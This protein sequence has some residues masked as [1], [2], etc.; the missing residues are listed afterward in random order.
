MSSFSRSAR[1]AQV[2]NERDFNKLPNRFHSLF[3]KRYHANFLRIFIQLQQRVSVQKIEEA[4]EDGQRQGIVPTAKSVQVTAFDTVP[5]RGRGD[6]PHHDADKYLGRRRGSLDRQASDADVAPSVMRRQSWSDNVANGGLEKSVEGSLAPSKRFCVDLHTSAKEDVN[7]YLNALRA[8]PPSGWNSLYGATQSSNHKPGEG[9]RIPTLRH[10]ASP[11]TGSC[12]G[13]SKLGSLRVLFERILSTDFSI[14]YQHG[15]QTKEGNRG[16]SVRLSSAQSGTTR[17]AYD[18]DESGARSDDVS[19]TTADSGT[20]DASQAGSCPSASD[21]AVFLYDIVGHSS[22]DDTTPFLRATPRGQRLPAVFYSALVQERLRQSPLPSLPSHFCLKLSVPAKFVGDASA[23]DKVVAD[24]EQRFMSLWGPGG[25]HVSQ[26]QWKTGADKGGMETR[27]GANKRERGIDEFTGRKPVN[28]TVERDVPDWQGGM[29]DHVENV[30]LRGSREREDHPLVWL[31]DSPDGMEYE[32][33]DGAHG[34]NLFS[35]GDNKPGM[36]TAE[37]RESSGVERLVLAADCWFYSPFSSLVM[38]KLSTTDVLT[39]LRLALLLRPRKPSASTLG[40]GLAPSDSLPSASPPFGH[41]RCA[42]PSSHHRLWFRIL[43]DIFPGDPLCDSFDWSDIHNWIDIPRHPTLDS[44]YSHLQVTKHAGS[45]LY[46]ETDSGR[47]EDGCSEIAG[48]IPIRGDSRSMN[49][50]TEGTVRGRMTGSTTAKRRMVNFTA[51]HDKHRSRRSSRHRRRCRFPEGLRHISTS[52]ERP[53]MGT[54]RETITSA[55]ESVSSTGAAF[56]VTSD[57]IGPLGTATSST[58]T[59]NHSSLPNPVVDS[60]TVPQT[61]YSVA[62]LSEKPSVISGI[63]SSW[64]VPAETSSPNGKHSPSIFDV[65]EDVPSGHSVIDYSNGVPDVSFL[66]LEGLLNA[67]SKKALPFLRSAYPKNSETPWPSQGIWAFNNPDDSPQV[68]AHMENLLSSIQ[69]VKQYASIA[70]RTCSNENLPTS[71]L[72]RDSL[73]SVTETNQPEDGRFMTSFSARKAAVLSSQ[74]DCILSRPSG[75]YP[76]GAVFTPTELSVCRL[77]NADSSA[78]SSLSAS[79]TATEVGNE[80]PETPR[81]SWRSKSPDNDPTMTTCSVPELRISSPVC[82]ICPLP[83]SDSSI[84]NFQR[85]AD[86]DCSNRDDVSDGG[87]SNV[88]TCMS[89]RVEESSSPAPTETDVVLGPVLLPAPLSLPIPFPSSPHCSFVAAPT[90]PPQQLLHPW[91]GS[92][93]RF[94]KPLFSPKLPSSQKQTGAG[95]S[96]IT[97]AASSTSVSELL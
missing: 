6:A 82:S 38:I 94:S 39:A 67:C 86:S 89:T 57:F 68:A 30:K 62:G 80:Q 54:A 21:S 3:N 59:E 71:P 58:I 70:W 11:T 15:S 63:P 36:E 88:L 35:R 74:F 45:Q 77:S 95:G 79:G 40:P 19:S 7:E 55:A 13:K 65:A 47:R 51:Q 83:P 27:R 25:S 37:M 46:P 52:K 10:P 26:L 22:S 42:A 48:S 2:T 72:P 97:V 91:V 84:S 75:V 29:T 8:K 44:W 18:F 12:R 60:S 96:R 49:S 76:A 4:I 87:R 24:L 31:V 93:S 81:Q 20:S 41:S 78:L 43:Q 73:T 53:L 32:N 17:R 69:T 14:D 92:S 34:S 56:N 9:R 90:Q 85:P 33:S 23:Q 64:S 1:W 61:F 28:G 5:M 50:C 66:V 16:T